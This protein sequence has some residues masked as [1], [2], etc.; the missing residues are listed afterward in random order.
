MGYST[1]KAALDAVVKTNGRQ[2]ITGS[3]LNGVM[4]Q[5][6]QGVDLLERANPADTSGMNYVV[7][8]KSKTFAEQVTAT[9]TIYE[10]RD[11][12]SLGNLVSL[13]TGCRLVF[14][15]GSLSLNGATIKEASIDALVGGMI[16][17]AQAFADYNAERFVALVNAG[18]S[19]V[20]NNDF[21]IG[22][23]TSTISHDVKVSGKGGFIKSSSA[24]SFD[25]SAAISLHIKGISMSANYSTGL[26]TFSILFQV[27]TATHIVNEMVLIEDCNID[28]VR[29][30]SHVADD[31]DQTTTKD[32][33]KTLIFRNNIVKNIGYYCIR[34]DNCLTDYVEVSGN[35]ISNFMSIV[36]GFALNNAYQ[37]L[38][39]SRLKMV[40]IKGNY[41]DNDGYVMTTGQQTE[42]YHSPFL[43]EAKICVFDDNIIKNISCTATSEIGVYAAYLSADNVV[44]RNNYI[45][46]VLNLGNSTLN[47]CF[48]SKGST[49]R[50][51]NRIICGNTFVVEE[52]FTTGYSPSIKFFS[53]QGDAAEECDYLNISNNIVDVP[54]LSFAWGAGSNI[55]YHDASMCGNSV[56]CGSINDTA[57]EMFRLDANAD[58][59]GN[60]LVSSNKLVAKSLS[61]YA[62]QLIREQSGYKV[63]FVDNEMDGFVSYGQFSN[64]YTNLEIIS[65]RN[66]WIMSSNP[67]T[68]RPYNVNVS[69]D[70]IVLSNTTQVRLYPNQVN[71]FAISLY[72]PKSVPYFNL[73]WSGENCM[74]LYRITIDCGIGK[75][76]V[77]CRADTDSVL[78]VNDAGSA[79]SCTRTAT[80]ASK[81]IVLPLSQTINLGR[82]TTTGIECSI[83]VESYASPFKPKVTIEK[84]STLPNINAFGN[85]N[86]LSAADTFDRSL[87]PYWIWKNNRMGYVMNGRMYGANGLTDGA[88]SGTTAERP[89]LRTQ[90]KGF[91]YFDT[92]KGKSIVWNGSTWV[93]MD[94]TAIQ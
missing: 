89:S 19:V 49:G 40:V 44:M 57:K 87:R 73:D 37:T 52:G 90:D 54:S 17:N 25:I 6:L 48:K 83:S 30:Y 74:G 35:K 78:I 77:Y 16:P 20:V 1:L 70:E 88:L 67:G 18:F 42:A 60:I 53:L 12:F 80:E 85:R 33:V 62:C 92:D 69:D 75:S 7:L 81:S 45:L 28:N 29:V 84:F 36:F 14:N 27:P 66:R 51:F 63:T 39:F 43:V 58:S 64:R 71:D 79:I 56:L 31:V 4:T 15:G 82:I 72:C 23:A 65:K 32:G 5:I 13:P 22:A 11:N 10:I 47:E 61:G 46:N 8:D 91:I 50:N 55:I 86:L 26:T 9:N 41:I 3:N 2:Q 24:E 38:A 59:D 21:Y 68:I 76:S 94:G 34:I 93:N